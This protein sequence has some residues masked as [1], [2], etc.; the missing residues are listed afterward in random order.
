[1]AREYEKK[2]KAMQFIKEL[3]RQKKKAAIHRILNSSQMGKKKK[4]K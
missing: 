1:M 2:Q 3:N 4:L